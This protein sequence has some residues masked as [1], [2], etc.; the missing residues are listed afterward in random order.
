MI[1]EQRTRIRAQTLCFPM[2]RTARTRL[3]GAVVP[4]QTDVE[5]TTV[6]REAQQRS[7]KL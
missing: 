1:N 4:D 2:L 6:T 7:F 5:L 3:V